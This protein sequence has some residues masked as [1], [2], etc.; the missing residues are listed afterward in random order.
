MLDIELFKII[1]DCCKGYIECSTKTLCI[2][3]GMEVCIRFLNSYFGF[4]PFQLRGTKKLMEV[5][6]LPKR[7]T[8]MVRICLQED[9]SSSL[10]VFS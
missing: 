4:V 5:H 10:M 9:W 7:S 3:E 2:V 6:Y 8:S 1:R